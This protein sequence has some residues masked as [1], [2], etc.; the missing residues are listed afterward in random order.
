M[1]ARWDI[2]LGH[3]SSSAAS[4]HLTARRI[5]CRGYRRSA[6][7][8][9]T[10]RNPQPDPSVDH[11]S[12]PQEERSIG[13]SPDP[14]AS[15]SSTESNQ[16]E[17]TAMNDTLAPV[18]LYEKRVDTVQN[19]IRHNSKLDKETAGDLAVLVLHA[20]DHIPEDVRRKTVLC[21][22][23]QGF[24]VRKG[25]IVARAGTRSPGRGPPVSS[26]VNGNATGSAVTSSATTVTRG[27]RSEPRLGAVGAAR[28]STT[29]PHIGAP[30]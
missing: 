7:S 17:N 15:T 21:W 22:P 13:G 5:P 18:S 25:R 1:E 4:R 12:P 24:A 16:N 10:G 23:A 19:A 3:L 9:G 29:H 8:P 28:F 26:K 20:L 30:R 6:K 27:I 11:A 14:N 2:D